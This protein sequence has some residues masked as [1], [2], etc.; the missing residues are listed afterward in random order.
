MLVQEHGGQDLESFV[1]L[2]FDEARIL[3]VQ[4]TFWLSLLFTFHSLKPFF[5]FFSTNSLSLSIAGHSCLGCS[6]SGIW[7]WTS[8]FALVCYYIIYCSSVFS[9]EW[10]LKNIIIC[11][12]GNIL[13]SRKDSEILHFTLEGKDIHLR[14]HG[15]VIS[16]I[17]FTLS[18]MNTGETSLLPVFFQIKYYYVAVLA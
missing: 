16:I 3:L 17:D 9:A 18:R 12:R 15:L 8:R 14:T 1:L 7:I 5:I 11:D 13:L 2:N 6:R 4:V 10:W